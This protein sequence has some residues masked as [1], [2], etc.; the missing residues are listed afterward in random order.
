MDFQYYPTPE[1]LA[2]KAWSLFEDTDYIRV[3]EPSAGS[4]SL[5]KP[6]LEKNYAFR[7]MMRK[8]HNLGS[9]DVIEIDA[10]QHPLLR[11]LGCKVVGHDFLEFQGGSVYSHI[12]MNPPFLYGA[13]HLLHAWNIL[14][15]GE[16]VCI[17]NAETVRNCF[18]KERQLLSRI[19][20][21]HG[22]VE[23]V[24]QAFVGDDVERET[25]V[26]IALVHL[27]KVPDSDAL[28]GDL[29][30]QLRVDRSHAEDNLAFDYRQQ[31]M[32]PQGYI[33]DLV[34]RF[35]AAVLAAQESAMAQAKAAH[36]SRLLGL[37]L[38]ERNNASTE[39]LKESPNNTP[40][41]V[42]AAFATQYEDLK[43]RAWAGVLRSTEV[44]KRLSSSAQKRMEKEFEY[45]K[46][47]EFSTANIYGF[48]R[49]LI[50]SANEI[51]EGMVLDVFDVICRYHE[52]N[53]VFYM[54]WK[55]N[56]K[57]RTA[58]MR[59][60]TTRFVL[61]GHSTDS[62]SKGIS[63]NSQRL[64]ADFDKVFAM[65]DGKSEE[66][67]YGLVNLFKDKFDALRDGGRESSDYFEVRYYP[68]RGTIHFFPKSKELIDRLNRVVGKKRQWLPPNIDE[69]KGDFVKQYEEAEK[70]DKELRAEFA[71]KVNSMKKGHYSNSVNYMFNALIAHE[72]GKTASY[73]EESYRDA[74]AALTGTLEVILEKKGIKP[75]DL[76]ENGSQQLLLAA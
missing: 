47:L 62:W 28:V 24:S 18:S 20:E 4:G 73:D 27:K 67:T 19:I 70:F 37:S 21:K 6:M 76:L 63:F 44:L 5:V 39:R 48:I 11:E 8:P 30:G 36:Y 14:Y 54:G 32:L 22:R 75:F 35:D 57:H 72:K 23:F 26:E 42:R 52:D 43:D 64:L 33:E 58:G 60:K 12:I 66:S 40:K 69:M 59:L 34:L 74:S 13:Q 31:V 1:S 51:Q 16:I 9:L 50:E 17:L 65:L 49:G 25:D 10:K 29:L 2:Q 7:G 61:P 53:T 68:K 45:I 38:T 41:L 71:Q 3:L 46:S 56:T 55:S 15:E